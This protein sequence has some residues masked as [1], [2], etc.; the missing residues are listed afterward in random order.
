MA[1][2]LQLRLLKAMPVRGYAST[3]LLAQRLGLNCLATYSA[4]RSLAL[5]RQLRHRPPVAAKEGHLWALPQIRKGVRVCEFQ[6]CVSQRFG[7]VVAYRICRNPGPWQGRRLPMVLFDAGFHCLCAPSE[8]DVV[9]HVGQ[10]PL[11]LE[12]L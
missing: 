11:P 6:H 1:S 4:A 7:E 2:P 9:D 5:S 10:I 12:G 3:A 8:L